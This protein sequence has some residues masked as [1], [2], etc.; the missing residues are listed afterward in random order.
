MNIEEAREYALSLSDEVTEELF[1]KE[2]ISWRIGGKW[3]M[4]TQLDAEEPRIAVKLPPEVG[5]GLREHYDGVR[6]A[7]HMNKTHWNDLYLN[8]LDNDFVKEQITASFLLVSK[9]P[10]HLKR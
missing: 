9:S 3:F 7:Y 4:L 1:A 8:L 2:W 10:K 6:P 5:A